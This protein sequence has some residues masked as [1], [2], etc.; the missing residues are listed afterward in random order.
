MVNEV[1]WN[2]YAEQY[3]NITN[4]KFNPAYLEI[5]NKV[6]NFYNKKL[7]NKN[8]F[9]LDLCGGTGNFS[10]PLAQNNPKT[11]FVIVDM[12]EKMLEKALEKKKNFNLNNIDVLKEDVE[13]IE[14]I[15]NFYSRPISDAIMI[16]GL[17]ATR[18]KKDFTK[19][20]R[21]LKNIHTN[22]ENN[23]SSFFISDINRPLKTNSWIP[24]C[25]WNAYLETK[26]FKKTITHFY[27]NDQAKKANKYI[28]YKQN[29]EE[30]LICTL[31][32][33][34]NMIK[35][36]G[37]SKIIEKSDKYYRRRDNLVIAYK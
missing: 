5:K 30:Y 27:K 18:S 16:H 20:Y 9:V 36:A 8:N 23:N 4:S 35:E 1:N 3:D 25:I 15:C 26:S 11:K 21:I 22:L 6:H 34:V 29:L 2:K 19:P 17:Y 37:F 24:Y 28:D 10:I 32:E 13:N 31:D 33:F 7:S 14:K 12:S